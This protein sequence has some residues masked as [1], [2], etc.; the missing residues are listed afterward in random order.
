[1]RFNGG[2]LRT[3]QRIFELYEKRGISLP[4]QRLSASQVGLCSVELVNWLINYTIT[5]LLNTVSGT[6]GKYLWFLTEIFIKAN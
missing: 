4:A 2:L 5:Y 3:Q 6:N 1:M